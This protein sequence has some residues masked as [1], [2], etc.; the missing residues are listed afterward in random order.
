[1]KNARYPDPIF[2][3]NVQSF[4]TAFASEANALDAAPASGWKR[5]GQTFKA[6][7]APD[8]TNASLSPLCRFYGSGSPGP[9]THFFTARTDECGYLQKVQAATPATSPRFNFEGDAFWVSLQLNGAC[10]ASA[11]VG[12]YRLYNNGYA[13]GKDPNLR[14]T[15]DPKIVSAMLAKGWVNEGIGFCTRN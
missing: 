7:G 15:T 6:F 3:P 10:L 2:I 13:L 12:V 9:N 8:A 4:F 11:P 5:T 1:M 14:F